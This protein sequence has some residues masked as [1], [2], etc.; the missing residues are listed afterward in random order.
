[1]ISG[2]P[3]ADVAT[4]AGHHSGDETDR[5]FRR[6]CRPIEAAASTG[7][8]M[9]P[10]V[11]GAVAFIM[12]NFTGIPYYL[13]CQY[14][15]LPRSAITRGLTLVHFESVRLNLGRVPEEQ[16]VGLKIALVRNW[17][18]LVPIAVLLYL[19]IEGFSPAYIAAGSAVTVVVS[20]WL[21]REDRIGPRRFIQACVDTCHSMVPLTAAVRRPASYRLDRAH[22]TLRQVHAD[23]VSTFRRVSA[24]LTVS[25]GGRAG[26]ARHGACPRSASTSWGSRFWRRSSSANSACRRW[27]SY[28]H[29][30]LFLQSAITPPVAVA[31]FA[32]VPLP[33]Q[34]VPARALCLQARGRRLRAAVLLPVQ[35]RHAA[36]RRVAAR[37][38]RHFCRRRVGA[39]IVVGAARLCKTAAPFRCRCAACSFSLRFAW[40][41][42]NR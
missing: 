24:V 33:R 4:P 41:S 30:V 17:S 25:C 39:D 20:S 29:P 13:I 32:A 22:R 23:A 37:R 36:S 28:V 5:H 6:A 38:F 21:S 27:I 18:R 7:G 10:P 19:L 14:A 1:M 16:I 8:A 3:V 12:S 2:S 34:S 26:P 40:A 9:L 11:M 15:A 35:Q 31:A 42:R